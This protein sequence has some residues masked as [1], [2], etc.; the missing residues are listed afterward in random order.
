MQQL[1]SSHSARAVV[2]TISD[3]GERMG[4]TVI[5][6]GIETEE[7]SDLLRRLGVRLAQGYLFS[8]PMPLDDFDEWC[9][10]AKAKVHADDWRLRTR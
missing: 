4:L 7:Q 8:P 2:Q 5:A 3:L 6:E 10:G 9:V 1:T